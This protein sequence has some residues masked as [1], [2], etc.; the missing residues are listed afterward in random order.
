MVKKDTRNLLIE[1]G[2]EI[3]LTKGFNNTGIQEV[4]K[5]VGVPKGSFYHFFKSKDDFG[6]Q[7]IEAYSERSKEHMESIFSDASV[8]PIERIRNFFDSALEKMRDSGF[9]GGCLIG[10]FSQEMGDLCPVFEK[11]LESK[12]RTMVSH[13]A[14]CLDEAKKAGTM[15][16]TQ[17]SQEL[18]EFLVD[19]WQ[20]ALL[21]MKVAK[22]ERPLLVFLKTVFT[23]VLV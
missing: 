9:R 14:D 18:A 5:E 13:I 21:R 2:L 20:G 3:F 7:V 23:S 4:L 15:K 17:S 8:P 22:S 10:N 12:I 11:K 1:K 16:N 6:L 19:G